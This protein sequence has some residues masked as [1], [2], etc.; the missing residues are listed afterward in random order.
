MWSRKEGDIKKRQNLFVKR[1]CESSA[2]RESSSKICFVLAKK[3]KPLSDGEDIA[4][5][6]LNKITKSV[7]YESIEREVNEIAL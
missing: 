6:C 2:I 1:S 4:K 3:Y 5:P 7:G